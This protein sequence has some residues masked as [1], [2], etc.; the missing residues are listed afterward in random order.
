MRDRRRKSR[1]DITTTNA[2]REE[3]RVRRARI[4]MTE[5]RRKRGH[6]RLISVADEE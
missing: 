3:H 2:C 1:I 4:T 5:V 6:L